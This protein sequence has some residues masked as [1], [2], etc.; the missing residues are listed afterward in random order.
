[1]T[2]GNSPIQSQNEEKTLTKFYINFF[3][4][5]INPPINGHHVDTCEQSLSF[6]YVK[7]LFF[8]FYFQVIKF[9]IPM[10]TL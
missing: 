1:M 2:E 4:S 6:I 3:L 10:A 7:K 9:D 8:Y 5:N